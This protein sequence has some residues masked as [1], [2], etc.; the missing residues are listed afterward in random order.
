M[1]KKFLFSSIFAVS[2]MAHS[3]FAQEA[4]EAAG[5]DSQGLDPL[6]KAE[7]AYAEAL[8]DFGFPD[9]AAEVIADTKKKWPES[10]A[11]FFAIEIRGMLML[12]KSAEAE[13]KIAALPDRKSSKYWAARLEVAIDHYGRGRN[14][15]CLK[16]YDEFFATNAKPARELMDLVRTAY[17]QRA[18]LLIAMKRYEAAAA[19]LE[20]LMKL[21]EKG[22]DRGE[23][24]AGNTWGSAA[25][26]VTDLYLR[27][28]SDLDP[29]KRGP[30]LSKAKKVISD[31][32]WMRNLPVYFGRAIA[33]KAHLELLNG[34]IGKA[35]SIIDDYMADLTDIHNQLEKRDPDGIYGLLKI[36]P[37][38][39]C[40]Y[41]LSDLLWKEAQKEAAKPKFD[42]GRIGDLLF[43]EKGRNNK[44]SGAGAYNHALNVFI[45]YPYSPWATAAEKMVDEIKAFMMERF[46]TPITDKVTPELR[47]QVRRTRFRNAD[48]RLGSGE[49]EKAIADYFSVLADYPESPESVGAVVKIV[50]A[51]HELLKR[52]SDEKK[53]FEYR[54]FADAVEGYL[55]ERFSGNPDNAIMN[56][57]G[58]G[59]LTLAGKE[60]ALNEPARAD[61]L[62]MAFIRNYTRHVNAPTMTAQ[63]AGTAFHEGKYR[64][65]LRYCLIMDENYRQS[66]FYVMSLSMASIAYEKIGERDNAITFLKKYIEL[67]TKPLEQLQSAMRLAAIYQ[68]DGINLLA[69]ASTNE[70]AEAVT[71]QERK[72]AISIISGIKNF[73]PF[74]AKIEE[75]LNDPSVGKAEKDGFQ[76]LHEKA[77]LYMGGCWARLIEV[78]KRLEMFQKH[79]IDPMAQ[80]VAAFEEYVAKYPRG[81]KAK[82]V[83]LNLSTI[84]TT[85]NDLVKSKESLERLRKEFPDSNEAK[86]SLPRLARSL[87]EH[88][89]TVADPE[90]KAKIYKESSQIYSEMIRSDSKDYHPMDYVYAGES[91][92][93]ARNWLLADSAF[94]KAIEKAGTNSYATVARAKIGKAKA[95]YAKK[96]YIGARENLDSFMEDK[97]LAGMQIATNA[98]TMIVEIAMLQGKS[99]ND[100]ALRESHY[101]AATKAVDRLSGYWEKEPLWK[102]DTVDLMSADIRI[103]KADTEESKGLADAAMAT[104]RKVAAS[105]QAFMQTRM[106]TDEKPIDKFTAEELDNLESAYAKLVPVLLKIG[107]EQAGRAKA[108][109]EQYFKFYPAGAQREHMQRCLKEAEALSAVAAPEAKEGTPAGS[110]PAGEVK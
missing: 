18:Q 62:Y 25:C 2:C 65:A 96:D 104:R 74:V 38:P 101:A 76:S 110:A 66:H 33:M 31:L 85:Q 29:S 58:N 22:K 87:V 97:K 79:K 23:E 89:S 83:Y 99:E 73:K 94:E 13:Q 46:N 26:E 82:E 95:L 106:P 88:A 20:K 90:R 69:T 70:T 27:I 42:K 4:N 14:K 77:I 98:C 24:D 48:E 3:L 52:T 100:N 37:M 60:K 68:R 64:D 34:K 93:E 30:Y 41:L 63:F 11:I 40:R 91:L 47:A 57:G 72:A 44:R 5:E 28:A 51:Y 67:E 17:W 10:D 21:V 8:T 102:R 105:L 16:I 35:Q 92:I 109:A 19:D 81:A 12:G 15:E 6:L 53:K 45:R 43:G 49:Y 7:I 56:E 39:Q 84:Y 107:P 80:A 71:A 86:T 78:S 50:E 1:S 54:L 108:L 55:A 36:S 9:F 32:L 61:E 59:V 75:K 103:A